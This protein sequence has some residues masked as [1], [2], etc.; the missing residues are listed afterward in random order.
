MFC[1]NCGNEVPSGVRFCLQC[2]RKVESGEVAGATIVTKGDV[3]VDQSTTNI[4]QEKHTH[5]NT[6]KVDGGIHINMGDQ[7]VP[8]PGLVVCPLCGLRNELRETFFCRQCERDYLC[9]DHLDRKRHACE[10]CSGTIQVEAEGTLVREEGAG[11][12]PPTRIAGPLDMEFVLIPAG[13]FMMGST[14]DELFGPPE[15]ELTGPGEQSFARL[16]RRKDDEHHHRVRITKSF[17]MQTTPVTQAQWKTVMAENPSEFRGD[18]RPVERVSWDDVQM[19]LIQLNNKHGAKCRLPTEA[20]WEYAC[21]AGTTTPF[22]FGETITSEQANFDSQYFSWWVE[23]LVGDSPA[24]TTPV[25]SF[26]PNAWGLYDMHGNV[27]EFCQD[28]YQKYYYHES[29]VDDPKGPAGG[30]YRVVRGGAYGN[31]HGGV[32]ASCR[33]IFLPDCD[34]VYGFRCAQGL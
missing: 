9:R 4:T 22:H 34:Q 28:W 24:E 14:E 32:R 25:R 26:P 6:A 15:E 10:E 5:E 33:D 13:E 2:G 12:E 17:Y 7:A 30:E 18:G 16:E 20:E 23:D 8:E 27:A 11:A 21:R 29:P 19:F 31:E 1:G 3:G